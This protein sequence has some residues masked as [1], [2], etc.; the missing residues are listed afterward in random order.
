MDSYFNYISTATEEDPCRFN[1]VGCMSTTRPTRILPASL[2]LHLDGDAQWRLDRRRDNYMDSMVPIDSSNYK[3]T[4]S[5]GAWRADSPDAP[6]ILRLR[7][8]GLRRVQRRAPSEAASS[9]RVNSA[10][11]FAANTRAPRLHRLVLQRGGN[12]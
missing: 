9:C 6:T 10:A 7:L 11:N 5:V 3:C 12:D 2:R 8:V 1:I 4:L